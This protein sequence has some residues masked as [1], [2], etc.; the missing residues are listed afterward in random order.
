MAHVGQNAPPKSMWDPPEGLWTKYH[1]LSVAH[2]RNAPWIFSLLVA[3]IRKY[4]PLITCGPHLGPTGLTS[5]RDTRGAYKI[6]AT[7][8]PH[9][10]DAYSIC[11]MH[12]W[13][14]PH[15]RK[16]GNFFKKIKFE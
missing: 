10:S 13:W 14:V 6:C 16:D 2:I 4:M 11:A 12:A 3:H 9:I 7:D 8:N 5:V 15:L 1:V